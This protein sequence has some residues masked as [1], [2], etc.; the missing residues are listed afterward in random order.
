MQQEYFS[1]RRLLRGKPVQNTRFLSDVFR[2]KLNLEALYASPTNFYIGATNAQTGEGRFFNAKK[3]SNFHETIRASMSV[4][5]LSGEPV[6]L[7]GE[8]YID[9]AVALGLPIRKILSEYDLT[10]LLV[11]PNAPESEPY[12]SVQ[13][14][15]ERAFISRYPKAV[16]E[17]ILNRFERFEEEKA[18]AM[19]QTSIPCSIVWGADLPSA[20]NNS[21]AVKSATL[22]AQAFMNAE[23]EKLNLVAS[24]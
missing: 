16:R 14:L 13:K 20:G 21:A 8:P 15:I 1:W 24:S 19:K 4:P 6:I 5:A 12:G 17:L 11:F 23:L 7:D 10:H 9:G 3:V 18:Y 2:T 22:A